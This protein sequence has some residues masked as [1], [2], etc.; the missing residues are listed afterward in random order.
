MEWIICIVLVV[1]A[2]IFGVEITEHRFAKQCEN[3]L[4][5]SL[6]IDTTDPDGPYIFAEFS[7]PVDTIFLNK[8]VILKIDANSISHD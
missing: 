4:V 2:F 3:K 5:G 8:Y 6:K 1:I 7:K